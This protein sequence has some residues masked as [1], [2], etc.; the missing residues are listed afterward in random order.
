MSDHLDRTAVAEVAGL[1]SAAQS[2]SPRYADIGGQMYSTT[3]LLPVV[4]PKTPEPTPLVVH[5]LTGLAD[6]IEANRDGL[7]VDD[8][9]VHVADPGRV[10]LRGQLKGHHAQRLTY[11]RAEHFDRFAAFPSFSF[12]RY[13]PTD[14]MIIALQALFEDAGDRAILLQLVGGVSS[15]N[16]TEQSDDG[17]TQHVDVRQ[18]V[19]RTRVVEAPRRLVLTPF[20]T[21]PEV[22]QPESVFFVRLR[23]NGDGVEAA[24]FEADG[25]AWRLEAIAR[26]EAWLGERFSDV[27]V[28]GLPSLGERLAIIA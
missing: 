21:F 5:T 26:I 18:G 27:G 16:A 4:P 13:L 28:E 24:L 7:S 6:Y 12:G 9:V 20:R 25:G 23:D 19:H 8:C 1:A 10:E 17:V 15:V 14:Q 2:I 3:T 11:I 22:A